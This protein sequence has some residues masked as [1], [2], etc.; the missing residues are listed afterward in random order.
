MLQDKLDFFHNFTKQLLDIVDGLKLKNCDSIKSLILRTRTAFLSDQVRNQVFGSDMAQKLK[1]YPANGYCG[2]ACFSFLEAIK[3]KNWQVMYINETWTY[4]PHF[5]LLHK[6]T[7]TVLD[8]TA[9]QFISDGI[10][11]IPYWM[12]QKATVSEY[13]Q[14]KVKRFALAMLCSNTQHVISKP[15][16]Y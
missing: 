6:P 7:K 11:D 12:G 10:K 2:V 3:D 1:H 13:F 15:K 16:V 9:D 8:L 14:N 4:G 5:Y